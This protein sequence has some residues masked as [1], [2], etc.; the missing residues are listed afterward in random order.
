M[1]GTLYLVATPIGNLGDVT[2][3]A[4]TTLSDVDFVACEDTRHTGRLLL[5][6]GI[7]KP[8]V[9]CDDHT[10][11]RAAPR[12]CERIEAGENA[13]LVSDAGTPGVSDPGYSVVAQALARNIRIIPIPGPSS[14]LAALC[15]SGLPTHA[16]RFEG[17]L[18][19]KGGAR[20]RRLAELSNDDATQVFFIPPHKLRTWLP[21]I[22]EVLGD[23]PA[24]LARELTKKFEE[25]QRGP[26]SD[27]ESAW[28]TRTPKG[29]MVLLVAGKS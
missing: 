22:R 8:M 21:D 29:E 24:C 16:F 9:R 18:P 1:T 23:R 28:K 15:A 4:V 3:R 2:R 6:L 14:I 5:H 25:F 20:H 27:I 13:A 19:V 17:Y 7:D 10:E 11:K 26:L 12:I